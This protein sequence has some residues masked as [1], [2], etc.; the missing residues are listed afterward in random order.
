MD[1]NP[2]SIC[3]GAAMPPELLDR[4]LLDQ[5]R[6]AG[7][8]AIQRSRE[9]DRGRNDPG[10]QADILAV[11]YVFDTTMADGMWL[12]FRAGNCPE[13]LPLSARR[14][15]ARHGGQLHVLGLSRDRE[16]CLAA[17]VACF[18]HH[19]G[20]QMQKTGETSGVSGM[21]GA[22]H[23]IAGQKPGDQA[24]TRASRD[25]LP[26]RNT[27]RPTRAMP[28]A[29]PTGCHCLSACCCR[30]PDFA[31][32]TLCRIAVAATT[33]AIVSGASTAPTK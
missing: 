31:I 18:E 30:S 21:S 13:G 33:V 11:G 10:R 16:K 5:A 19:A 8:G 22:A 24:N 25:R 7:V 28:W 32:A 26:G 6:A 14:P 23:R 3:C 9:R 1:R 20:L 2:C 27:D 15:G 17:T 4:A 29:S 12:A